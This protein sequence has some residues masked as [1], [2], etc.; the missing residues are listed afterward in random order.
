MADRSG[1]FEFLAESSRLAEEA[2]NTPPSDRARLFRIVHT[3]KGNCS[4]FGVGSVA[5]TCH[6][7]E[8]KMVETDE[9]VSPEE[10]TALKLT[11]MAFAE[12]VR[13][14]V[15]QNQDDHVEFSRDELKAFRRAIAAKT[16]PQEL[17]TML[18]NLQREPMA[19]RFARI[20]EQAKSLA[21]TMGKEDVLVTTVSNGVRLDARRWAPFWSSFV[22]LLRNSL[23]HGI[24]PADD[25][26]LAGKPRHGH[27]TLKATATNNDIV[28]EFTDDGRGIDWHRVRDKARHLGYEAASEQELGVLLLQ[29]GLST[30]E[31]VTEYS[32]RGAGVSACYTACAEL[33]GR[34][35]LHTTAGSGTTIRF[36][37]PNDDSVQKLSIIPAA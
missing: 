37:I 18:R 10:L 11:W 13:S 30:K 12:K 8:S 9:H 20:A 16:E 34:T 1:L 21:K 6:E 24:E 22:H 26:G 29:G 36:V 2:V 28:I 33:G 7:L 25:R 14:V 32:G 17:L 23:D 4:L 5:R 15:G 35:E 27:L 31:E 19:Q 3:L